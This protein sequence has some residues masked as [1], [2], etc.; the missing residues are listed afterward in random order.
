MAL[1]LTTVK[2]NGTAYDS[3]ISLTIPAGSTPTTLPVSMK[4]F[5]ISPTTNTALVLNFQNGVINLAIAAT[6]DD[7]KIIPFRPISIAVSA[8]LDIEMLF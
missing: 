6:A 2:Q 3:A 1:D 7:G 4:A 5:K 8:D